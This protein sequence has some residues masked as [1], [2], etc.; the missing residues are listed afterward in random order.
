MTPDQRTEIAFTLAKHPTL[1]EQAEK[2][3]WA[4]IKRRDVKHGIGW[5]GSAAS[6]CRII[7]AAYRAGHRAGQKAEATDAS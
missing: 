7:V 5:E 2:W 4:A 6:L 3:A 1:Q